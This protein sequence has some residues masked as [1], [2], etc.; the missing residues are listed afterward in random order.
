MLIILAIHVNL[1][2]FFW[3]VKTKEEINGLMLK[4]INREDWTF[5]AIF[6]TFFLLSFFIDPDTHAIASN[7]LWLCDSFWWNI[8][9]REKNYQFLASINFGIMPH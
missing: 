6:I 1:N 2:H 9:E 4:A 5:Y 8:S 7:S 3:L